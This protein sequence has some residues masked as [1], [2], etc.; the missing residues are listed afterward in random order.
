MQRVAQTD[1]IC[2]KVLSLS[3]SD[4]E[5]CEGIFEGV[6]TK[7]FSSSINQLISDTKN[8]QDVTNYDK[9]LRDPQ[10]PDKD[11]YYLVYY[12]N[13]AI[14]QLSEGIRGSL[15]S[16]TNKII[17]EVEF[18]QLLFIIVMVFLAIFFIIY[19]IMEQIKDSL[20]HK[21][22]IFL[23]DICSYTL[24]EMIAAKS[25]QVLKKYKVMK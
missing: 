5:E 14:K 18:I 22:M 12:N 11:N 1:N 19:L 3:V 2:N 23:I 17:D 25:L 4:I 9:S 7:G 21:E 8:E 13:L 16:I 20:I 6:L 15:I 24:N 10:I